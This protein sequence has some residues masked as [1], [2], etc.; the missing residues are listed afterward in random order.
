MFLYSCSLLLQTFQV[1]F[2]VE[3]V[4]KVI[5][6][7]KAFFQQK[8]LLVEMG[9][10]VLSLCELVIAWQ[11]AGYDYTGYSLL[12]LVKLVRIKS[13]PPTVGVSGISKVFNL[14]LCTVHKSCIWH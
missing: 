12:R 3:M 11:T 8:Y 7:N 14:I 5:A 6:L 13:G 4:V 9:I 10:T 1:V 2:T